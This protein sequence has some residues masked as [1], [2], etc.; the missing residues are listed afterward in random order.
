MKEVVDSLQVIGNVKEGFLHYSLATDD[1]VIGSLLF[2]FLILTYALADKGNYLGRMLRVFFMPGDQIQDGVRTAR[3]I[4][5]RLF[6]LLQTMMS[7]TLIFFSI[8]DELQLMPEVKIHQ[9][10]GIMVIVL[11]S[12]Y[13]IKQLIFTIVNATLLDRQ[14]RIVWRRSYSQII[15]MSGFPAFVLAMVSAFLQVPSGIMFIM[16]LTIVILSELCL[17]YKGFYIFYS[18]RYGILQLIVYFC[19]LEIMP[20]LIIGKVLFF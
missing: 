16:V 6:L 13:W 12:F 18:K 10:M 20:L 14:S 4:Y 19:T 8:E 5:M 1:W 15:E 9:T 11:L 2:C 7:F 3:V 17:L